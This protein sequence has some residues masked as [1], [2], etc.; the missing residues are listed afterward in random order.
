[1]LL[2]RFACWTGAI[3]DAVMLPPMLFPAIGA[4]LFGIPY[5]H[6]GPEYRYA[7]YV[8]ASLMAG[9][10]ALL[11]WADRKPVE[12]RGVILLTVFPVL[13]GMIGASVYAA[14]SGL[15]AAG[16]IL[17]MAIIQISVAALFLAAFFGSR[18]H[19][20]SERRTGKTVHT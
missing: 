18:P 5:F 3:L 14:A 6:P 17:P 20:E 1:M 16:R 9:W 4:A 19:G 13:S 11:V 15:L 12:R 10:T 8:G 2:L 7:M